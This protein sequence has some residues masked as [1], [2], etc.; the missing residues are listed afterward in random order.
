[1]APVNFAIAASPAMTR[2]FHHQAR[3]PGENIPAV[4][5]LL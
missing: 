1:L 2:I 4:T 3:M 5:A